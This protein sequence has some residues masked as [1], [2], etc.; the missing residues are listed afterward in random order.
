MMGDGQIELVHTGND[1]ARLARW[2]GLTI[3][4][5]FAAYAGY[6]LCRSN[7]SVALP[8]ITDELTERGMTP[9]LAKERLGLVVSLGT[10]GYAAGKFLGGGVADRLGGRFNVLAGMAGS[11]ACTV[12]FASGSSLAV[13]EGAWIGNRLIQALGWVG[14]VK[15]ASR[16]VSHAR[17]GSVMGFL[18]LS[19]L[20]G[21]AASRFFMGWLLRLGFGWRGVFFVA[22]GVLF[23]I[24]VVL[25][26]LLH[27][28]PARLGLPEPPANPENLYGPD[29][30]S[31]RDDA[32][33]RGLL[34]P[35][36][37]SRAFWLVSFLSVGLTLLRE[38]FNTWTPTY[39][40]EVVGL[41]KD[42]AA[43]RSAYFPLAGGVSVMLAGW[44]SDRL[45]R[46]GRPTLLMGGL[47]AAALTLCTLAI[48]S[49][50][51]QTLTP[52]VLLTTVGFFLIGPY[53]FLAGAMALDL[54][55]KRGSATASG[56][57]DGV[58]YLGGVLAG[59]SVAR[60]VNQLGWRA[61]FAVLAG[62]AIV[63]ALVAAVY[64]FDEWR[65]YQSGSP[66]AS[67]IT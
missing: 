50:E 57:I 1:Q 58:G 9:D 40:V 67:K 14:I 3:G 6:Y 29:E 15:L 13:F 16:W 20:F 5:M 34:G 30:A 45:G 12:W 43:S 49:F 55:G 44:L 28:S 37:T 64:L 62:V 51:R 42:L 47:V 22:A 39:Y 65:T 38:T 8:L 36:L 63:S 32:N 18:S 46:L 52:V 56:L 54:G 7:L 17:Y 19:F 53:S 33:L 24:L 10:L 23:A 41:S 27:E 60:L 2:Q 48:G 26:R 61:T 35:L 25:T 66:A 21:D 31:S 11:V 59:V 4:L